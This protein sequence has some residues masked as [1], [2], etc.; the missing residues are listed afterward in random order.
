MSLNCMNTI[1][2]NN[3]VA[4]FDITNINSWNSNTGLSINSLTKWDGAV[5]DNINLPDFGLTGFDNGRVDNM[6]SGLTIS[7]NSD[8]LELYRIGYNDNTGGTFY[9]TYSIQSVTGSSVG[10][11]FS[12][13]GG[14]LQG[15]FKLD[16]YNYELIQP[17]YNNGITIETLIEILPQSSGIFYFMGTRAED[18]Y[19]PYYSGETTLISGNTVLYGG[20]DTGYTYT[21]TGIT[22]SED[23]YL[24][25]YDDI[26]VTK[27]GFKEPEFSGTIVM[28]ESD[29]VGNVGD[30][31]ISF[32]ITPDRKIK[33]KYVN[34]SGLLIQ[35]E[36]P[37]S[38]Y[39]VGWTIISIVFKP[40]YVIENYDPLKCNCYPRRK[41]DLLFYVN[42]RLFWKVIDFTEFYFK[43]LN[44]NCE[45]QLG[46]PFNISWGGGS[47]GLK[48]SW[49][50]N[51]ISGNTI[52]QD[53]RKNNLLIE[54]YFD[55]SY[56]GNI[57]KLRIYDN[58]LTSSE[59]LHNSIIESSNCPSYGIL[60]NKGGRIINKTQSIPYVPQQ[61][62]GSDIR[63][64]IRY[65]N[66]DGSYRDLYQMNEIMVVV[67]SRNNPTVELVKFKKVTESGWLQL[68]WVNDTTYDFIVP[69][70]I[71]S[72]HPNETLFAEIK[73]QWVDIN[74]I[75]NV[76]D[77]IFVINITNSNLLDNTIKNY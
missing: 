44:N 51:D 1:I 50:Y 74:D 3:L 62:S 58:A 49:H 24:V 26:N 37:I 35:N 56:I 8:K 40:Y 71:T 19:N 28:E 22:T 5:S 9:D 23:N 31:A 17:R 73:F 63:K 10:K 54:R 13:N 65:R 68:I 20:K 38:L 64:S 70:E 47:F 59:I 52:V 55:D 43:S 6:S 29:Q 16:G 15:F 67:K 12:L 41:G 72:Q 75:D 18:K 27:S 69:D 45:K 32:E 76:F 53:A 14:Y 66:S 34:G 46:V 77:K 11:Y 4:C 60:V 57:Q 21:F 25:S 30:N 48:H 39:N 33:Y 42:G 61:S 2:S 36:S 7:Y